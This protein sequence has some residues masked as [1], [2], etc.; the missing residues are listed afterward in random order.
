[1][2]STL[3]NPFTPKSAIP[4]K[5][6]FGG[7]EE[8]KKRKLGVNAAK[9]IKETKEKVSTVKYGDFEILKPQAEFLYKMEKELMAKGI[10]NL[11]KEEAIELL[12]RRIEVDEFGNIERIDF[13]AMG[14]KILPNLDKLTGLFELVCARNQ[15]TS[16]PSLDKLTNLGNLD[17]HDNK[18]SVLPS[19]DKLTNL[20][21]LYCN[22]NKLTSLPSLDKLINLQILQCNVNNLDNLP[23]LAKLKNLEMLVCGG[24]KFSEQEKAKIKSQ[25][26]KNC[27]VK[28]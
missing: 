19:L 10:V 14:L 15:L 3:E 24:N 1:M 22:L 18:L 25:V 21:D 5:R 2:P 20:M 26:P 23:S 8:I 6:L 28:I 11:G 4:T 13:S 17:C 7:E 16:L 9:R 12:T 27:D